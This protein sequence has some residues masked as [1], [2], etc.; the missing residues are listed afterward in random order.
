MG[1]LNAPGRLSRHVAPNG[2][3]QT[4]RHYIREIVY[5][6]TDGL[7]TTFAVVAG[8]SGGGLSSAVVMICGIA[9]LLADGLSMG[10]GNF[11][12]ITS[13]ES[14]LE[15]EG[16]PQEEAQPIRHGL[17][18]FIAFVVAGTIPLL[19]YALGLPEAGRLTV[20]TVLALGTMFVVGAL[21]S[22]IS[23]VSWWRGGLEM[24]ALGSVVAAVAFWAGKIIAGF[25]GA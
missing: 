16:L 5:G 3:R 9:N 8:V 17:A 20:A 13:H 25:T 12:A 10:V 11:L 2:V 19:P 18:T 4:V 22:T 21:R 23:L 1:K 7:I 24:L 15:A 6:A 14:V